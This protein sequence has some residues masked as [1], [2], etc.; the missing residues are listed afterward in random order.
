[1]MKVIVSTKREE[2]DLEKFWKIETTGTENLDA[3]FKFNQEFQE[4][5]EK[6]KL[7]SVTMTTAIL[8]NFHG[9]R[10]TQHY[11]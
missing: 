6:K 2:F 5:Y 9:K 11:H 7:R 1:M 3:D 8:Q 10:T 4:V